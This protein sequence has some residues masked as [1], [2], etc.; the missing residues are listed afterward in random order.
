MWE[1]MDTDPMLARN[2]L[3]IMSGRLRNNNLT[4]VTTQSDSLEFAQASTVDPLTGLHNLRWIEST[5]MRQVRRC[6]Q[7]HTP[8]CLLLADIDLLEQINERNG[9]LTGDHALK[10]AS[11]A[12][13][14]SLR[15]QDL[16]GRWGGDE[17]AVLLP[18]TTTAEA[19]AVGS[20]LCTAVL[21]AGIIVPPRKEA[22]SISCG[23]IPFKAEDSMTS[24]FI[25]VRVALEE[26]KAKGRNRAELVA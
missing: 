7:D 21:E 3:A 9:Y 24:V 16:V 5:F 11:R 20:R 8:V 22:L 25:R 13:A 19:L 26:A 18:N 12:L 15:P 2:L 23:V 4:L 14:E 17:F 6:R 10:R 1:M